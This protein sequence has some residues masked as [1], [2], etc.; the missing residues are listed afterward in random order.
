MDEYYTARGWDLEFG[1]PQDVL[2]QKLGL[3][4]AIQEVALARAG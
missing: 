2:L 4:A 1:W 3:E